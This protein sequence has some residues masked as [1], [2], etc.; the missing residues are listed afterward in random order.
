[1]RPSRVSDSRVLGEDQNAGVWRALARRWVGADPRGK[2]PGCFF[3]FLP[4]FN[5]FFMMEAAQ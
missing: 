1:M 3:L 2:A 5:S 4:L